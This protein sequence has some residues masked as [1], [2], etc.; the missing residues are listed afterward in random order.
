MATTNKGLN[1]PAA[2]STAWNVPLNDNFGFIDAALGSVTTKSATGVGTTPVVLTTTEYRS[3]VLKFTG[4][5]TANVT[6]QIPSGV[7]GSWIIDNSTSGAF[8]LTIDSAGAGTSV[9]VP[10]SSR[11]SVYSDG[12]N[13]QRADSLVSAVGSSGQVAISNGTSITT[14]GGVTYN[15]TKVTVIG[16]TAATNAVTELLT[17]ESQSTG[18]PAAGIGAGLSF[19]AETSSGNVETGGQLY[20]LATDVTAGSED[21][22]FSFRLMAAGASSTE[23]ARISPAGVMTLAG[24]N[25]LTAGKASVAQNL[26]TAGFVASVDNDGAKSGGTTYTPTPIGGNTKTIDNAGS[27][28]IA[29]PTEGGAYTIVI[30]MT[31]VTGAGT[32]SFTGFNKKT[33]DAITTTVGHDFFIYITKVG[34]FSLVNVVALQ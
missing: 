22:A 4:T 6:Y 33:G 25:V 21:F 30:Q 10:Q 2:S 18:T 7:G 14:T 1:Q 32:V 34:S 17:I 31:N 13:I 5:L 8:T 24:D 28:T 20:V 11:I 23:I 9:V 16:T 26:T 3:L 15:G 19:R 27:F 29:E 12:T